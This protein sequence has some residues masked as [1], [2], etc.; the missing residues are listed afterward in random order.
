MDIKQLGEYEIIRFIEKG[1]VGNIYEARHINSGQKVAIK[2]LLPELNSNP[3]QIKRFIQQTRFSVKFSH[4]NIVNILGN[5][6]DKETHYMVM[7]YVGGP[8]LKKLLITNPGG[9]LTEKEGI[10]ICIQAGMGLEYIH[11]H[12]IVHRDIKPRNILITEEGKAKIGD[13][14]MLLPENIKGKKSQGEQ[15]GA[16]SYMSPEQIRG[17]RLDRRSD[18]Y[19]FGVTLY[20]ILTGRLPFRGHDNSTIIRHHLSCEPLPLRNVVGELSSDT[21]RITLKCLNKNVYKRYPNMTELLK[22]LR[23]NFVKTK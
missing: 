22:E 23:K 3:E 10:K 15:L 19:S 2:T 17:Q 18:I 7:E 6:E 4:P 21:E 14:G 1:G 13:F 9:R 8:N 12:N 11:N 20:E 16:Y 5:G